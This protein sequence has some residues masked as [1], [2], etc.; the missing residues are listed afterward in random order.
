MFSDY[1]FGVPHDMT[2]RL[3]ATRQPGATRRPYHPCNNVYSYELRHRSQLSFIDTFVPELSNDCKFFFLPVLY[4]YVSSVYVVIQI[5]F[6][7]QF[8][9]HLYLQLLVCIYLIYQSFHFYVYLASVFSGRYSDMSVLTTTKDTVQ[10]NIP[11]TYDT[12]LHVKKL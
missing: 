7:Y 12:S 1:Y 11:I 6:S 3:H 8:F 10:N 9:I 4:F 5:S 2:V